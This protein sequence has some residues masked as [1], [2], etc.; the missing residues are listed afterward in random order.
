MTARDEVLD[1]RD[2]ELLRVEEALELLA[3]VD[4]ALAPYVTDEHIGA[5]CERLDELVAEARVRAGEPEP[6]VKETP[7]P[8]PASDAASAAVEPAPAPAIT[9]GGEPR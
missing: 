9:N 1:R 6:D 8:E 7:A 5:L 4:E 2:A 3:R